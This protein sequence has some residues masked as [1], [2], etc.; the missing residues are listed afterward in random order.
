MIDVPD[1]PSG[2]QV[3]AYIDSYATHFNLT[4]H[5]RLGVVINRLDRSADD[6]S[7][8][9]EI[10]KADLKPRAELFDRVVVTTGAQAKAYIPNIEGSEHFKGRLLHSQAF[11]E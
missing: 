4:P 1:Y 10:M 8:A 6:S 11:K 9:L 5:F 2:E 3:A 7:W